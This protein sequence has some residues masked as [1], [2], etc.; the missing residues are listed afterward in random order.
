MKF[1]VSC[2][3]EL[4]PKDFTSLHNFS[5][6]DFPNF[7]HILEQRNHW[8]AFNLIVFLYLFCIQISLYLQYNSRASSSLQYP[9]L[10]K[11]ISSCSCGST[12]LP[13]SGSDVFSSTSRYPFWKYGLS[14]LDLFRLRWPPICS[15]WPNYQGKQFESPSKFFSCRW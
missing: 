9:I 1:K 3:E 13:G 2:I 14:L 7:S 11:T 10:L 8:S 4:V 12:I 5:C 15:R 6:W